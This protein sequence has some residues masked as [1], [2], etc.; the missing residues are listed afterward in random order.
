[1]DPG[2]R[3]PTLQTGCFLN[4]DLKVFS[5]SS[6]DN[7]EALLLHNFFFSHKTRSD[8]LSSLQR[9]HWILIYVSL[10]NK[11]VTGVEFVMF[12]DGGSMQSA[13]SRQVLVI[14]YVFPDLTLESIFH[15]GSRQ[16]IEEPCMP[17]PIGGK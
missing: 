17:P 6:L 14:Q 7:N 11:D 1:M 8:N 12:V 4:T 10:L 3:K 16:C 15:N 5:G 9:A 13:P 2:G